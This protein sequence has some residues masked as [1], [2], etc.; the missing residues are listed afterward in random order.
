MQE[1]QKIMQD[2]TDPCSVLEHAMHPGVL[3]ALV[4]ELR[5]RLQPPAM[6]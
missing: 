5:S 6:T 1:M 4:A 2:C 3:N